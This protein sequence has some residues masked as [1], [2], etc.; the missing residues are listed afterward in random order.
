MYQFTPNVCRPLIPPA[1]PSP[2][3]STVGV[4]ARDLP[5]SVPV[6]LLPSAPRTR[7]AFSVTL[8][9]SNVPNGTQTTDSLPRGLR[10]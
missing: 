9:R 1:V 2:F 3:R 6:W 10:N 7:N 8:G 4:P 5:R